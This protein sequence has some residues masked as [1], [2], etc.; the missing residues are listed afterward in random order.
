MYAA[1]KEGF[2]FELK[3]MS[4]VLNLCKDGSTASTD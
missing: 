1:A 2:L 3:N 4:V